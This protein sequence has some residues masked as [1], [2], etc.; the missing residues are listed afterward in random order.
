MIREGAHNTLESDWAGGWRAGEGDDHTL[1]TRAD[2]YDSMEDRI[3]N[4]GGRDPGPKFHTLQAHICGLQGNR[5]RVS[6]N[7]SLLFIPYVESLI[8]CKHILSC[9]RAFTS[10][11]KAQA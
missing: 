6:R 4:S 1:P 8:F 11:G 7:M 5:G 2:V 3:T 10:C 9:K